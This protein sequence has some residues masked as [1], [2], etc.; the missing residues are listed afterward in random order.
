MGLL[1][2]VLIG[3]GTAVCAAVMPVMETLFT[4][5]QMANSQVSLVIMLGVPF[6]LSLIVSLVPLNTLKLTTGWVMLAAAGF[7]A[8]DAYMVFTDKGDNHNLWPI[9]LVI[10]TGLVTGA[11]IAGSL[12]GRK[13][14]RANFDQSGLA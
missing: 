12:M 8:G 13:I 10:L 7:F 4:P 2:L 5:R 14:T 11:L 1:K 9:E 6:L 3:I